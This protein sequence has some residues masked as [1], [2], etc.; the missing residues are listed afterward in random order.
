ML[1]SLGHGM[2]DWVRKSVAVGVVV[3]KGGE[4]VQ[5][6]VACTI[7]WEAW[8]LTNVKNR[9]RKQYS[10]PGAAGAEGE[11]GSQSPAGTGARAK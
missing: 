1:W 8:D 2:A 6:G 7:K 11:K 10:E 4:A 9:A 3:V 5:E